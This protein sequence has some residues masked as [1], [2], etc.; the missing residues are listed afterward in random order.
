[1]SHEILPGIKQFDLTGK[2]AII[3]GG[4]RGL[5]YAMAAGLASAGANLMLVNR[6]AEEGKIAAQQLEADFGTKVVSY[7]ADITIESE[8][9]LMAEAAFNTFGKIDILIN[10]AGINIRGAIDELSYEDFTKVMN[11]NVN[12]TWLSARAV[13]PFMKKNGSGRIINLASTLGLIGLANRTPY[14]ASKGAVVNMT[15]ALAIELAPF[16]IMVNAIC[17]GPF[18]TA[19]NIPIK[20]S[21]DAIKTVLGATALGR[22][23]ELHEIQ[24]AAI[25][26][27]S[28][29]AS[30]MVGSI[31]TVDGGWT[32]K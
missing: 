24:G 26:L 29:A 30:Y 17:P 12:G 1:M 27:A 15:R 8:A 9:G 18:L 31:L 20:D 13:T 32:A 7:S 5:G 14:T 19:M 16:N 6:N 3:T 4:S 11:V 28:D 21:E 10:S 25:F 2:C 22:W 23:A